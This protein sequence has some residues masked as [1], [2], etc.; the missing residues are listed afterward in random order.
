[1]IR[2]AAQGAKDPETPELLKRLFNIPSSKIFSITL[3]N[4]RFETAF[5]QGRYWYFTPAQVRKALFCEQSQ[6]ASAIP[7]IHCLAEEMNTVMFTESKPLPQHHNG[8]SGF[9]R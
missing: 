3:G 2:P 7:G 4:L 6:R 5:Q 8:T 1:T 9:G